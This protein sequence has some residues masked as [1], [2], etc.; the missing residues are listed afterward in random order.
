M[1][2]PDDETVVKKFQIKHKENK[3]KKR[4]NMSVDQALNSPTLEDL[5]KKTEENPIASSLRLSQGILVNRAQ[6]VENK[7]INKKRKKRTKE[8]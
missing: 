4:E 3:I 1:A 7:K 6:M 8:D 2:C 5:K